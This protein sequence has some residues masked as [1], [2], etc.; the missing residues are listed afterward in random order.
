LRAEAR[1]RAL[2]WIGLA[3]LMALTC[4][5]AL[6]AVAGARRTDSSY[7]RLL[8][9]VSEQ[10]ATIDLPSPD[11]VTWNDPHNPLLT[12][13]DRFPAVAA[14][15]AQ[16]QLISFDGP[17]LT[18]SNNE[19]DLDAIA[20]GYGTRVS[21][22]VLRSGRL[23]NPH[24]LDE[25]LVDPRFAAEHHLHL[26]SRFVV[27]TVDSDKF[28][29]VN[30]QPGVYRGPRQVNVLTVTGIGQI[31]RDINPTTVLEDQP[32]VYVSQAFV[33]A[34]SSALSNVGTAVRL[35]PG[36]DVGTF[37]TDVTRFARAHHID[38][39]SIY[40][41]AERDHT[42]AA[43]RA[44]RPQA[45][46]LGLFA[47]VAA[48][49]ALVV[50]GQGLARQVFVDGADAPLLGSL[51]MTAHQRFGLG[52]CRVAIVC[53]LGAAGAVVV[54]VALSPL[55]PVGPARA[56]EPSP[57]VSFDAAVL[58]LGF[59]LVFAVFFVAG[60]LPAWRR[61]H[62]S[63]SSL[64]A[65]AGA[66]RPSRLAAF[67]ARAGSSAASVMGVRMAF[68]PGRGRTAVPVRSALVTTTLAL[69]AV[70]AVAVFA[71]N[72]DHLVQTP[73]SYG[74]TWSASTGFGFEPAPAVATRD[75][76]SDR[77]LAGVAGGNYLDLHL[78][79]HDVPAVTF[80][81]LKGNLA[82]EL[83]AG[84]AP[85][86][87]H[88]LVLG[89]QTMRDAGL[90][91]GQEVPVELN[92][93]PT[94][95][96]I[97]GRA[98]F[99]RL[100]A[101][102][103]TPTDVGQGAML[104]DAAARKAGVDNADPSDPRARYSVYF[105]QSAPGV[106]L[107]GVQHQ[108]NQQ[109]DNL[110]PLCPSRFCVVGPQPPGDV[111]AYGRVHSTTVALIALLGVIAAAALTHALVTSA[112]RRRPDVAVLKTLGFVA[113][114]AAAMACW[115]GLAMAVAALIVGVPIGIGVGRWAWTIFAEQLGVAP[116]ATIPWGAALVTALAAV[117]VGL[118]ASAL[119]AL[120]AART[121]PSALLRPT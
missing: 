72:L 15:G 110:V 98:V 92:G 119:P 82:P 118:V 24:R 35:R 108:L 113:R 9:A 58:A 104:T 117:I 69:A 47:L 76:L 50:V 64:T 78:G 67:L 59:L 114:Q 11:G 39:R 32:H 25:A 10:D 116:H 14:S 94:R 85:H 38:P 73:A 75:L 45:L 99:P 43:Q 63:W 49:A 112:R 62:A 77:S 48:L 33:D 101:G 60:A 18:A 55:F 57:G 34:H 84:H 71:T 23:P 61:A 26:G 52:L 65:P 22:P 79:R 28:D 54:A 86:G 103:F 81:V 100:G 97:V 4:G 80:D 56:T 121:R 109:L 107:G 27:T 87:D 96:R 102:I 2:A 29:E 66:E 91:L 53:L 74:W 30:D 19:Q 7:G 51:G 3:A 13:I 6:A 1:R 20:D 12:A 37:Q 46:G 88:E 8:H 115:Q 17:R 89:T 31:A 16:Y 44:V 120:I 111:V 105:L 40:F 70:V 21:R 42:N 68:E 106:S 93:S 95:M 5:A 41:T 36:A 90:H 83:L